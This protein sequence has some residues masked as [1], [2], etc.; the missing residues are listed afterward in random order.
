MIDE[1]AGQLVALLFVPH[2]P[3]YYA[4]AFILFRIFDILKPFPIR[5]LEKIGGGLGIMVDDIA[6]GFYTLAVIQLYIYFN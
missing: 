2:M 1:V 4:S 5:R 3:L 6:A